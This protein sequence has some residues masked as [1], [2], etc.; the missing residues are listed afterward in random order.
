MIRNEFNQNNKYE[1]SEEYK[2]KLVEAMSYSI[3]IN[4]T[5]LDSDIIIDEEVIRNYTFHYD[6]VIN[7]GLRNRRIYTKI[8][9]MVEKIIEEIEKAPIYND[10]ILYRGIKLN[11]SLKVGDIISDNAFMSKS[12]DPYEAMFFASGD[13]KHIFILHYN[14]SQQLFIA[15]YSRFSREKEFLTFPG[16]RF[17]IKAIY[18][19]FLH[20]Y[21]Y[22]EFIDYNLEEPELISD[23]DFSIVENIVDYDVDEFI[24]LLLRMNDDTNAHFYFDG[25]R[26]ALVE[27]DEKFLPILLIHNE[28]IDDLK[29][30]IQGSFYEETLDSIYRVKIPY[31][32]TVKMKYRNGEVEEEKEEDVFYLI[33]SIL[34]ENFISADSEIKIPELIRIF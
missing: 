13:E 12:S 14:T 3:S 33:N 27:S 18:K 30:I 11:S 31:Y 8:Y 34:T 21:Y 23:P 28:S 6:K 2:N 7:K 4:D 16:E 1:G 22:L 26:K 20:T 29:R 32:F 5:E 10:F 24:I 25:E 17:V 15:P 9:K 19:N